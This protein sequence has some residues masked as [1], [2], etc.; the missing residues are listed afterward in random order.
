MSDADHSPE[1]LPDALQRLQDVL[2]SHSESGGRERE[3][4]VRFIGHELRRPLGAIVSAAEVLERCAGQ[5][6]IERD[7]RAVILRQTHHL[8]RVLTDLLE[9]LRVAAGRA[10][11]AG[12]TEEVGAMVEEMKKA[13]AREAPAAV[14]PPAPAR[15]TSA[16]L[17]RRRTMFL[18]GHAKAQADELRTLLAPQA[19]QINVVG[20]DDDALPRLLALDPEVAIVD[21][22]SR[23]TGPG[24]AR[25]A[26]AAG[27][28]G[29]MVA[30]GSTQE[31]QGMRRGGFDAFLA[32]P[33]TRSGLARAIF[34]E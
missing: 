1:G 31:P 23:V 19:R 13:L 2:R 15:K 28:A 27:Y 3:E 14:E 16:P 4:F 29:R 20:D 17:P 25:R 6:D 32:K 26:R 34:E 8:S 18:A 30:L 33:A 10:L 5:Q 22:D 9:V 24:F 7:A 21:I 11:L 12:G